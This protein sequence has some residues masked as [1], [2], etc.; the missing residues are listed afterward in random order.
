MPS[1]GPLIGR[2][3][4]VDGGQHEQPHA[5]EPLGELVG[6][7]SSV[8]SGDVAQVWSG[9]LEAVVEDGLQFDEIVGAFVHGCSP[10]CSTP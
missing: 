5:G 8:G 10:S 9:R 6:V 4:R 2:P 3:S 1:T 7:E